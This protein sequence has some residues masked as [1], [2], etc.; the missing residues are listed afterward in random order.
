MHQYAIP[1]ERLILERK[2]GS[3]AYGDV[4]RARYARLDVV[5]A[6]KKLKAASVT[7]WGLDKFQDEIELMSRLEHEN[8]VQFIGMV[9]V[10]AFFLRNFLFC[11]D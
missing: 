8:I 11:S 10:E 1:Y 5:V 4:W 9:P 2:V 7:K 3:G 6:V